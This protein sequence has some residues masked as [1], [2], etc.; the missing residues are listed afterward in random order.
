VT[1]RSIFAVAILVLAGCGAKPPA[2]DPQP[3]AAPGSVVQPG[4]AVKTERLR[5]G[6]LTGTIEANG[7]V[8]ADA[9]GQAS[10]AFPIGGQIASIRVNVGDPV[11]HGDVLGTLDA[12]TAAADIVQAQADVAAG[13]ANLAK[14]QA[15]ARPQEF[16]QNAATLAA[17]REKARAAKA[18]LDREAALANVGI[19]SQRELQQA[20]S[21]YAGALADERITREQGSILQAGARPQ[22][23]AVARAAVQQAEAALSAARTKASLLNLVAPFDGVITQRLKNPGETADPAMPVLAMVNPSRTVVEVELSQDAGTLVRRGAPATVSVDGM[24]HRLAGTVSAVSPA[25]GQQTGTMTVRLRVIGSL[26]PGAAA[27]AAITVRDATN[28]FVVPESA[29][30]KDPETGATLIFVAKGGGKYVR[31]PV[32]IRLQSG[33]RVAISSAGLHSGLEIVTQGAYELLPV[34]G[35]NTGD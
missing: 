33:N 10:L 28:A 20:Q 8:V 24:Q 3:S 26:T 22:D 18:E 21:S 35:G 5:R 12:R 32:Q 2:S 6:A 29:V 13:E 31:V 34:V 14:T 27:K 9:G 23:V 7:Q 30:V 4:V 25:F 15:R 19:A 16:A 1:S 17:V 11:A